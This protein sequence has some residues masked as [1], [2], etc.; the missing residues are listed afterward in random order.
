MHVP[1]TPEPPRKRHRVRNGVL[2]TLAVLAVLAVIGA[3][4]GNHQ[5]AA[6]LKTPS[7]PL[8]RRAIRIVG[9]V[10]I[11]QR[12]GGRVRVRNPLCSRRPRGQQRRH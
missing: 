12:R 5:N 1:P 8:P 7:T 6:S 11:A 4:E 10:V 9:G 2:G 3:L